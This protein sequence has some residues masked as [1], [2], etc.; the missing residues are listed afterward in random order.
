MGIEW[1]RV[2]SF[3]AYL[4]SW[5]A[6]GLGAVVGMRR[7][8]EGEGSGAGFGW[9]VLLQVAAAL[10]VTLT[11]GEG[12]LRPAVWEL[13]GALVLAPLGAGL[14]WW[15]LRSGES[16]LVTGGAFALVRHPMYLGFFLLVAATALLAS[17]RWTLA[18]AVVLYALGTEMRVAR[19]ETELGRRFGDEHARYRARTRWRWLPGLR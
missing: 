19:E 14:Y 1:L 4:A 8:S 18:A 9:G 13:A 11:L 16:G 2:V 6:V 3:C 12:A 10:P 17:A 5:V 15:A 7:K